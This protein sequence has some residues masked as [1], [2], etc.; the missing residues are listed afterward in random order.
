M[1]AEQA[2]RATVRA[3]YASAMSA[4]TRHVLTHDERVFIFGEGI[5]DPGAFLG[6]VSDIGREFGPR[7]CFDVPNSEDALVGLGVGAALRGLRPIFVNLRLDFLML[8]MNQIVNHAARWPAMTG[9][10]ATVPLTLRAIVGRSWGQAAQHAGALYSLFGN[11]PGLDVVLPA[12]AADGAGLF[13]SAVGSPRTTII[14]EE[15][16]IFGI[17]SDVPVVPEPVPFGVARCVRPGDDVSFIAISSMVAF[18]EQVAGE[19]AERGISA[20]VLD[21]RTVRPLDS[22]A[23]C[24]SASRTR[25]VAVFD[26]GW[27]TFGLASEVSRHILEA[28]IC[29]MAPL[30]TVARRDEHTPASCFLED[31]YYPKVAEAANRIEAQVAGKSTAPAARH[32]PGCTDR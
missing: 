8:A 22:D 31:D 10:R 11:V 7:R 24:R 15:R 2:P 9:Y 25:R 12:D 14:V 19:L 4:A 16:G 17:E 27:T 3:D 1:T 13:L 26:I 18:A 32:K 20:E 29:L 30:V 28:G 23:I 5:N 6:T 21:L